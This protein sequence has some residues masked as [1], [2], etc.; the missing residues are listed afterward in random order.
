MFV[1]QIISGSCILSTA[2]TYIQILRGDQIYIDWLR[3]ADDISDII[4]GKVLK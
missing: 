3:Y 4:L 1:I 2:I